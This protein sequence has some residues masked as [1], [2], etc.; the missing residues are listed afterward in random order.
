[1][2]NTV[3]IDGQAGTTGLE[4]AARLRAHEAIDLIEIDE[5]SRKDPD[6]RRAFFERADVTVLC[7]PDDA[8]REAAALT[9]N[10]RLLD[11]STAHR[12]NDDWVYGMPELCEAS[13]REIASAARVSNP[14]CYP[15]GFILSVRPLIEAG[16]LSAAVPLRLH[17]ISGYSGGGNKLIDAFASR[18]DGPYLT[19]PYGLTLQHK[20]VPEMRA[21]SGTAHTPLF[22]PTVGHFYKGM[23]VQVPL[24][25][26][27]FERQVTADDVA[28]LLAARYADEPFVEVFPSAPIDCA[29]DDGF[30]SPT[31]AN[32]TNRIDLMVFGHDE[33]ITIITRY[34]NLGK[35]ASGAAVQNLNLMLGLSETAGLA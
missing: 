10:C 30:L 23:L 21:Y 34:D 18:A 25:T 32:D 20:H 5:A 31:V 22:N 24:F 17:A 6:A 8:A 7:L 26:Q 12:V 27:E 28:E 1:M 3:F 33:Q 35:G 19:T 4:L 2:S 16:W 13:R 11:A 14:G 29:L 9:P 15:T